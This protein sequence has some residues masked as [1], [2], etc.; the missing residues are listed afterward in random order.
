MRTQC[1]EVQVL[2]LTD[3]GLQLINRNKDKNILQNSGKQ[4]SP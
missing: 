3:N 2:V 1:F 4:F